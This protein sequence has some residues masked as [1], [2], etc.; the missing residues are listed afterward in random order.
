MRK[1]VCGILVTTLAMGVGASLSSVL[2]AEN[3]AVETSHSQQGVISQELIQTVDSYVK[4]SNNQFLLTDE[5]SLKECL[6]EFE[7]KQVQESIA[8]ANKEINKVKN[9][10]K[11]VEGNIVVVERVQ[12][13]ASLALASSNEG[14]N[15]LRFH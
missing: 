13:N 5:E 3:S 11:Y 10:I 12:G 1:I 9:D 6:S 7:F 15:D 4:L 14:I 8:S 2:A